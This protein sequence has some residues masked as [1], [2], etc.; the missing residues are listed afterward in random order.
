MAML[1]RRYKKLINI[2]GD[3]KYDIMPMVKHSFTFGILMI[4]SIIND[5]FVL[6]KYE[7]ASI[8]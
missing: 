5:M 7:S 2:S 8:Y 4:M 6:L 1:L 3:H